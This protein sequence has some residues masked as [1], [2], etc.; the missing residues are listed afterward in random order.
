MPGV[1]STVGAYRR[2]A[3]KLRYADGRWLVEIEDTRG[4]DT[5]GVHRPMVVPAARPSVPIGRLCFA[6]DEVR[7]LLGDAFVA[8]H[9]R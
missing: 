9:R 7:E 5:L 4:G 2:R 1:P 8:L 3:T 6:V